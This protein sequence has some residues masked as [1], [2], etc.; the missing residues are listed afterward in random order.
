MTFGTET[1]LVKKVFVVFYIF[2][3]KTHTQRTVCTKE[4]T[5][6]IQTDDENVKRISVFSS[7]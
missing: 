4:R 1:I 2:N 3:T 5:H 6:Q 7:R